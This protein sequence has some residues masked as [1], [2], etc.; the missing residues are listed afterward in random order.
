MTGT[1]HL[2]TNRVKT[3]LAPKPSFRVTYFKDAEAHWQRTENLETG[4]WWMTEIER[5]QPY[6]KSTEHGM[7][8][9]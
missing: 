3:W 2:L 6:D 7:C 5:Y 9:H 8:F 4:Q 1:I